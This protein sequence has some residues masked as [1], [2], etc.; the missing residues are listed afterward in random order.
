MREGFCKRR[1]LFLF[2][3][4]MYTVYILHSKK[5]GRYYIGYTN[6]IERRLSDHNQKKYRVLPVL[7]FTICYNIL[8]KLKTQNYI[9]LHI[10]LIY[11]NKL[12]F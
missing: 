1:G 6:D 4:G 5:P 9:L 8:N 7:K 12:Y 2:D 10:Y 11:L 3:T